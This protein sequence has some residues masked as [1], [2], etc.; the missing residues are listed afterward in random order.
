MKE[1]YKEVIDGF[2]EIGSFKLIETFL[3]SGVI[4]FSL[5][6]GCHFVNRMIGLPDDN[7]IEELIEDVIESETG[8]EID[9]TQS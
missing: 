2:K 8:Q 6:G 5:F 4:V 3:F 1:V 7:F 9:L